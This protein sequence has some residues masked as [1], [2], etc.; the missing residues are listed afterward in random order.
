MME[1]KDLSTDKKMK[2]FSKIPEPQHH[3]QLMVANK[4]HQNKDQQPRENQETQQ[5][6]AN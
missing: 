4:I 6:K 2:K 5:K 3:Q 1:I